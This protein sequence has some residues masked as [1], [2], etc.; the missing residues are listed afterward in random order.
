M[1]NDVHK[2]EKFLQKYFSFSY[3]ILSFPYK[4]KWEQG[5]M[6]S[7]E[8]H[9]NSIHFYVWLIG[10][11]TMFI[12]SVA[13]WTTLIYSIP[14]YLTAKKYVYLAF[15]SEWATV[16]V[17]LLVHQIPHLLF[18]K[19]VVQLSCGIMGLIKNLEYRKEYIGIL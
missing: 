1:R 13:C 11:S 7:L 19:N 16:N 5:F 15:H 3:Q 12:Y 18:S 4:L 10:F 2:L 8:I 17:M 6:M 9:R 14:N